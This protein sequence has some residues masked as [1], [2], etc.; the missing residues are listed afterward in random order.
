MSY[1]IHI[2]SGNGNVQVDSSTS[3]KGLIVIDSGTSTTTSRLDPDKVLVFAKPSS[4]SGNIL[5]GCTRTT[6]DSNGEINLQFKDLNL[7][8]VT[9]DFIIAKVSNEQTQSSSGY[10]V[11]V[12]N[13][14][15]DLAFDSGLFTGDGGFGVTDFLD[16]RE[17]SGQY[18]LISTSTSNYVLVNSAALASP[19]A[20]GIIQA[21][22]YV[23]NYTSASYASQNGIYFLG[24]FKFGTAP[25][26]QYQA[27]PNLGAVF[28]TETG[29]V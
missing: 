21:F 13:S 9:C 4:S 22:I 7:N 18:D 10:G 2:E 19:S 16:A 27:I 15:G 17:G 12:F 26:F 8:S 23:N 1:G 11:H 25:N 20:A 24:Q 28:V 6:E 29:S 14:E 3:G 5:I